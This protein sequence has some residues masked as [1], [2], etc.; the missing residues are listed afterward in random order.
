MLRGVIYR[1]TK[2]QLFLKTLC[3]VVFAINERLKVMPRRMHD[4]MT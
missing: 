2:S 1:H 3:A 4:S